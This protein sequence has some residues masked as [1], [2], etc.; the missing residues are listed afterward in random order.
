MTLGFSGL[1]REIRILQKLYEL[2][3]EQLKLAHKLL[4]SSE[5]ETMKSSREY[6][7]LVY[8]EMYML[9]HD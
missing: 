2:K 4:G 1:E 6:R 7:D 9:L 8:E 5:G 3:C